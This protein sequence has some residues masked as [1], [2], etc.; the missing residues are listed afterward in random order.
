MSSNKNRKDFWFESSEGGIMVPQVIRL[1][2]I[3]DSP[4][5]QEVLIFQLEKNFF[6]KT[7]S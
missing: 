1:S 5:I 6:A 2:G 4:L 3:L 7:L